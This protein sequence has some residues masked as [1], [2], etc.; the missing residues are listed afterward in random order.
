MEN[1]NDTVVDQKKVKNHRKIVLFGSLGVVILIILAF[2]FIFSQPKVVKFDNL[3]GLKIENIAV[4]DDGHIKAPDKPEN[5]GWTFCGWYLDKS[6]NNKIDDLST[7][8]FTKTTT[9]YAKWKLTRYKI[10]Y[11]GITGITNLENLPTEYVMKHTYPEDWSE[12]DKDDVWKPDYDYDGSIPTFNEEKAIRG[13]SLVDPIRKGYTF[14]GW[15]NSNDELV[16][17][18]NNVKPTDIT[19]IAKWQ[20]N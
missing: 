1:R 19:L 6:F 7:Y 13:I 5:K 11:E 12:E 17:R 20:E 9:V 18:L 14:L 2:I 10:T 16:E 4:D 15:Y 8:T 3:K